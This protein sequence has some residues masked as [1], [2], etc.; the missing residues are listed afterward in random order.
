MEATGPQRPDFRFEDL[1]PRMQQAVARMGW[2]S[3]M[4]VQAKAIPILRD[5]RDLIVQSK[6]GSGKTGAFL[7]PVLQQLDRERR[8]CQAL[9]LAPTRE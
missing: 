5:R 8:E 7:L 6:T 3:P 4:P 2:P 9:V 1:S